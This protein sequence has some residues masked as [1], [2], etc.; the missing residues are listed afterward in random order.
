MTFFGVPFHLMIWGKIWIFIKN[1]DIIPF[2]LLYISFILV[3]QLGVLGKT[4]KR[5]SKDTSEGKEIKTE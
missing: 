4:K 5:P 3:C 2:I 1:T